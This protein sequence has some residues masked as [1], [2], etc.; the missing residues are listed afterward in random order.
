M[1]GWMHSQPKTES[2]VKA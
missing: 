2:P 1:H